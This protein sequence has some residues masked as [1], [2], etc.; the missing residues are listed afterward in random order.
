[1]HS[2]IAED[3]L[4]E[5]FSLV[6]GHHNTVILTNSTGLGGRKL[7]GRRLGRRRLGCAVS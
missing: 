3:A 6:E 5:I 4:Q 2:A 7:G 1:V